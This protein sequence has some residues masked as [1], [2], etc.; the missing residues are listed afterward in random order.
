M[1]NVD[2]NHG[3]ERKR[4]TSFSLTSIQSVS[5]SL[6]RNIRASTPFV[7][8]TRF[9]WYK[10]FDTS[11][12][13]RSLPPSLFLSLSL[14]LSAFGRNLYRSH[15]FRCS[16]RRRNRYFPAEQCISQRRDAA[17][18]RTFC[19]CSISTKQVHKLIA[20]V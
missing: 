18:R 11:G 6:A 3:A 12:E 10:H 1:D 7:E 2:R 15:N 14:Y 19:R 8:K 13:A 4:D 20:K 9:D 5:D 16:A 17:R